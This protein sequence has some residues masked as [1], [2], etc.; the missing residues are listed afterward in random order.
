MTVAP[1]PAASGRRQLGQKERQPGSHEHLILIL[2]LIAAGPY[3][4]LGLSF[5]SSKA[6]E[7]TLRDSLHF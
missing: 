1:F 6:E 7:P 3:A 4:S 5:P 2:A